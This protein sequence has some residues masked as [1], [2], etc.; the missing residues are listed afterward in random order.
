MM[1]HLR[2]SACPPGDIFERKDGIGYP[3]F[4]KYTYYSSAA[5]R[6]T[7]VNVLL[8]PDYSEDRTYPVLYLLH[9]Y[10]DNEDWMT[11]PVVCV[12]TMLSNLYARGEAEPM[13]V[14]CPYIYCSKEMPYCTG[15]NL[16]NSLNY[17]NFI[18]DLTGSLMPFIESRFSVAKGKEN[19]AITGFSMGGREALF[20]GFTHPD[21]FGYVGA[22]CPAPGLTPLADS[23]AH[24]GQMPEDAMRFDE[25]HLL[26]LSASKA[27]GVVGHFPASYHEMLQRNHTGH[28]WH[29][30][31]DT[32]HDP[33]SVKPHLYHF[34]RRIFG[35]C[36]ADADRPS[37]TVKPEFTEYG[38]YDF[39]IPWSVFPDTP[40]PQ[41]FTVKTGDFVFF[42]DVLAQ[43]DG[44][45]SFAH[46]FRD[47][48]QAVDILRPGDTLYI[49]GGIYAVDTPIRIYGKNGGADKITISSY[50]RELAVF[51]GHAYDSVS[52][53][54]HHENGIFTIDRSSGIVIRNLR[55]QNSHCKGISIFNSD[56]IE[57]S[58]CEIENTFACGISVWDT[59]PLPEKKNAFRGFRILGNTVR[60]ATTWDMIPAGRKKQG[61]PPHEAISIA[62]ATDFE[63]AYNHVYECDKEGID[64]KENS[65]NGT[66]HHNYVHD[67]D[68]Q[69]LYADAWFGTLDN[70][71]FEYNIVYR[72][73]GA[74]LALSVE[75]AGSYLSHVTFAHNL[76]Y[77]NRGTGMFIS[78]WGD[79]LLR[80][81]ITVAGNTF[82]QNGHGFS[83]GSD[84]IFWI[85]GGLHF[86][87]GSIRNMTVENNIFSDSDTFEIGFSDNYG[88]S[89]TEIRAALAEKNIVIR[90]NL[91]DY[92]DTAAF[93]VRV[94]WTDNFS[95][96]T[97][98]TGE[99]AVFRAP[100]FRDPEHLD[101]T[102]TDEDLISSGIGAIRLRKNT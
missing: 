64:V 67:C 62:G 71:R 16:T 92:R 84:S 93:P 54:F 11:R 25:P 4:P 12:S 81:H 1:N 97:Q 98:Y 36:A 35:K 86:Y 20:I 99:D 19:S 58:H 90:R 28:F 78:R 88:R 26:M 102:L 76:V 77:L 55:F 89:E 15:M 75:G 95:D 74:G 51:D 44:D 91:I 10:F 82:V 96:V 41:D 32:G 68:R 39:S 80:E 66:V 29:E 3:E 49:R 48:Q 101:F 94:G 17:D 14:V 50:G 72:N 57:I 33:S 69:G 52:G 85:T 59:S 45:G 37:Q 21:R 47:V 38:K 42:A 23:P 31:E 2:I 13:I 24:P 60:K 83:Y 22:A 63:V 6:E 18:N 40:V 70:V 100:L 5:E 27:D 34:V 43:E 56:N 9:G 46:P 8:P 87:S 30:M 73:R 61:E 79:D 65:R 7:N 53:H